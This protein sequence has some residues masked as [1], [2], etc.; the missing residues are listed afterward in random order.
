MKTSCPHCLARYAI[1]DERVRGKVLR[2]RCKRCEGVMKVV[3]E[4]AQEHQ[5]PPTYTDADVYR[6]EPTVT[7]MAMVD[8][9]AWFAG[10]AGHPQG[11]FSLNQLRELCRRGDV[12]DRTYLWTRGMAGWERIGT[13]PKLAFALEWVLDSDRTRRLLEPAHGAWMPT[14]TNHTGW[15]VLDEQTQAG[16][17]AAQ[18]T[19]VAE[20]LGFQAALGL[21]AAGF[22]LAVGGAIWLSQLGPSLTA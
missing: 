13:S 17:V 16:L 20:E 19:G 10:I 11:P 6:P 1:P 8:G 3:G 15:V 22:S 9:Q 7:R 12:H 14:P 21:C 5:R 18:K 4:G 2:I